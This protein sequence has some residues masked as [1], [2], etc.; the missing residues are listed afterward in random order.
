MSATVRPCRR[1]I[2]SSRS[3]NTQFKRSA[4]ARPTLLLP[5]PIK[6]TRKTAFSP[7]PG[8]FFGGEVRTRVRVFVPAALPERFFERS[9]LFFWLF[10]RAF[11]EVDFTTEAAQNDGRGDR[12]APHGTPEGTSFFQHERSVLLGLK[13]NVVMDFAT[14]G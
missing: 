9:G 6:P 8:V 11:S 3:S 7:E 13:V 14:N 5:A 4:R 2:R 10:F 12:S 1:S